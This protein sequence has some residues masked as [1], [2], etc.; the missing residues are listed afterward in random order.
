MTTPAICIQHQEQQQQQQAVRQYV[1][2]LFS[3]RGH[4]L[5][6]LSVLCMSCVLYV[7]SVLHILCSLR[8]SVFSVS[9]ILRVLCTLCVLCILCMLGPEFRIDKVR[10]VVPFVLCRGQVESRDG[11]MS[12]MSSHRSHDTTSPILSSAAIPVS[13]LRLQLISVAKCSTV[14]AISVCRV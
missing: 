7:L 4:M 5:C 10:V 9:C 14:R 3:I 2:N 13:V 8:I 1:R 6:V 12:S 11:G